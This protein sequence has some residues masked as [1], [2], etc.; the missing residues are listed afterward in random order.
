MASSFQILFFTVLFGVA[1]AGPLSLKA[2]ANHLR[3]SANGA[4]ASRNADEGGEEGGEEDE[5]EEGE[6]QEE[7]EARE[8]EELNIKINSGE[9][10]EHNP[11]ACC[12]HCH[13]CSHCDKCQHKPNLEMC[14]FCPLCPLCFRP[15]CMMA[16]RE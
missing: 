10:T 4:S 6:E 16:R 2:R 8:A 5:E 1:L 15:E 13:L 3:S 14:D 12:S 7:E 11:K 9:C